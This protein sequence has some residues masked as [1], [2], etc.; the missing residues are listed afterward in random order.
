MNQEKRAVLNSVTIERILNRFI[1]FR[2]T[3]VQLQLKGENQ[4]FCGNKA[5]VQSLILL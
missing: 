2:W 4:L 1:G 5:H 3:T